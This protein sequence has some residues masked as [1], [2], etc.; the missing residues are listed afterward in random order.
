MAL[1][2]LATLL[3]SLWLALLGGG[4]QDAGSLCASWSEGE[5][6]G[7]L[8]TAMLP[9]ASGLAV[10]RQFAGTLYHINDSGHGPYFYVTDE[11]GANTR[12]V[13]VEGLRAVDP[14]D[15]SLGPC[16]GDQTCLF[17]G[18]IG[19][20]LARRTHIEI[21]V[22]VEEAFGASASP[23]RLVRARYPDGPR[24]AEAMAVHPNGDL[25]IL[26]KEGDLFRLRSA[27]ARLYRLERERW[28]DEPDSV[29]TLT[30]VGELDLPQLNRNHTSLLGWRATAMDMTPDGSR[31][32]VLT[33]ENA[34][35]F[36]LDLAEGLPE[37]R[38]LVHGRDFRRIPLRTLP[39]QEAIAYLPGER[40]FLYSSEVRA[41]FT[42]AELVKVRCLDGR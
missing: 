26:S 22:L 11:T 37:S 30:F 19:D 17:L 39:Q 1:A 20:N 12:R 3:L 16:A 2:A 4:S 13:R 5:T 24:D 9:E 10:S 28:E 34:L 35:E 21:A 7:L 25:Y 15:L 31:F 18:D 41:P 6:V 40:S 33:Y 8:D 14:E 38:A 27:P 32:L 29:H 42:E 23:Y 36:A